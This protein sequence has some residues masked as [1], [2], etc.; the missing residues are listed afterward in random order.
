M[1]SFKISRISMGFDF[2][3]NL[4]LS[5]LVGFLIG[6]EREVHSIAENKKIFGGARTFALVS[7]FGYL[8]AYMNS[9][10][11]NSF[12][13]AFVMFSALLLLSYAINFYKNNEGGVTTEIAAFML[14]FVGA[15]F[16][17]VSNEF[18]ILSAVVML[19][20]LNLKEHV[21]SF[22]SSLQKKD[23][24]AAVIFLA[25]SFVVLP[26]L[27]NESVD[28]FGLLNPYKIW[29]MVV[30]VAGISFLGYIAI[31]VFGNRMGLGLTGLIGGFVSS[32]AVTLTFSKKSKITPELSNN[33]AFG[34]AIASTIMFARMLILTYIFN[35]ELAQTLFIPTLGVLVASFA[36]SYFLYRSTSESSMSEGVEFENPFE[37]KEALYMGIIFG[38]ILA[39]IKL[40]AKYLGDAGVY[41]VS[42][43]SGL[44]DVD[45]IVVSLANTQNMALEVLGAGIVLAAISN[46]ISKFA[47]CA[48]VGS[49]SLWL[50]ILGFHSINVAVLALLFFVF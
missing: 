14:F 20:I 22:E 2:V 33:L 5:A 32:T 13:A 48:S 10:V 38:V 40:G 16:Y 42:A 41:V 31:K 6:L 39:A 3:L 18:A 30:L 4:F 47:I 21:T 37:L 49:K 35:Q 9:F 36:Y 23:I 46:S 34:I 50:K 17:F 8:S 43:G 25:M 44:A 19:V 28:K 7:A 27:P 11:P 29:F 26:I 1:A 12:L 45:A 24:N 15:I